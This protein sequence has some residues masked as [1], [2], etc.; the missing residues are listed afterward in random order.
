M[1]KSGKKMQIIGSTINYGLERDNI[2]AKVTLDFNKGSLT[3][4]TGNS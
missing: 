4:N 2:T 1:S 3:I